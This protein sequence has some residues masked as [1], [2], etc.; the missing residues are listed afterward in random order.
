MIN[1]NITDHPARKCNLFAYTLGR[2]VMKVCGW[3]MEGQVPDSKKMIIIASPHTSNW[4]FIF[5]LGAAY[6]FRLSVNWLG[7]KSLFPPVWGA[8]M[9]YLGGVPIDRSKSS[10]MVQLLADD[11]TAAPNFTLVIPASGTRR[12]TEYWKSGFYQIALAAKIPV[13]C[14]YLDYENKVACLGYSFVPTGDVTADMDKIREFYKP[15]KGR[16]PENTSRIRLR[17][18]DVNQG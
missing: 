1:R 16:N 17:E 2:V 12:K 4:D 15:I 11:I 14:G 3:K 7:K 8:W 5:L 10:N 13:V 6:C 9:K 18:E